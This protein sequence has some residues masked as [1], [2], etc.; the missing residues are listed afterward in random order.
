M[1]DNKTDGLEPIPVSDKEAGGAKTD[2]IENTDKNLLMS[3][4]GELGVTK[5]KKNGSFARFMRGKFAPFW[6]GHNKRNIKIAAVLLAAAAVFIVSVYGVRIYKLLNTVDYDDGID[7][8]NKDIT[9][10]EDETDF[11]AM[12]EVSDAGSLNELLKQWATN[13][14][15][16]MY[17]KNVIN[18]ML[19]GVDSEDG[20]MSGARSDAMMLASVNLKTKKITL[21]SFFRDSYTYM[22][23]DG[24]IRY[25]KINAANNWGGPATVV[26]TLE[27]NYK[28][29]IDKFVSVD[30]KTFPDIIDSLGGVTV[31]VSEYEA[32]FVRR[33]TR[34]KN[35]KAGDAVKLTGDEALMFSRIRHLDS[36]I[37]RTRRQR[38]VIMAI[39]ERTKDAKNSQLNNAMDFIFPNIRTN[40][41]KSE[42]LSLGS[43]ALSQG[44]TDFDIIQMVS[45]AENAQ[46]S[47]YIN[48]GFV[49]IVD[50]PAEARA[51]QLALYGTTNIILDKNRTNVISLLTPRST[52]GD[53]NNNNNNDNN[54]STTDYGGYTLPKT[55]T[56]NEITTAFGTTS[57]QTTAETPTE[58]TAP[59]DTTQ[60]TTQGTTAPPAT[61][62]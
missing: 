60:A 25:N 22:D 28:I 51:V 27:N 6:T 11:S 56:P 8:S 61:N 45:P 1:D 58:T 15:E 41:T 18:V 43:K 2:F 29:E 53:S 9:Y 46:K 37:N 12:H 38:S 39:I 57:G 7:F 13:G 50:Y 55:T 36:D 20:T 54:Y 24:S 59:P 31:P 40:Y 47:A 30:F 42:I 21:V 49:W 52:S 16:K 32:R 4:F 62:P 34:Y 19:F 10:V 48:G 5:S 33:T 17:S 35:F 26:E 14:G 23:I 44:W 3:E